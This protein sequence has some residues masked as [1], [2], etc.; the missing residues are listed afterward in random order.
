MTSRPG[1]P[2]DGQRFQ[3]VLLPVDGSELS[4]RAVTWAEA[5]ARCSGGR[6]TILRALPTAE[7]VSVRYA[8]ASAGAYVD[9]TLV[10]PVR[11][12]GEMKRGAEA[13]LDLVR[14]RIRDVST[15]VMLDEGRPEDVIVE[16]ARSEGADVIVMSTRGEGGITR[17][18]LGSVTDAVVRRAPCP[19]L[20]VPARTTD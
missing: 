11:D 10:D 7:Q 14:R 9:P 4:E 20:V 19:V 5:L 1:Q 13:H 16:R 12:L 3:H 17:A 6:I 8:S 2:S 15:S 18:L